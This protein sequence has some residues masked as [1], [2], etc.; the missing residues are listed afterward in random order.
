MHMRVF[1]AMAWMAG[2]AALTAT[3]GCGDDGPDRYGLSGS[4][5]Y[6]GKPIAGGWIV[7][8]PVGE[9]PGASGNIHDGRYETRK[10][11]GTVGGPHTIEVVAFDSAAAADPNTEG[12]AGTAAKPMFSC[13]IQRDIPKETTSLDIEISRADVERASR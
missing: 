1:P 3:G 13:T 10:D 2:L 6:E 11:W 8:D 5:S 12:S 9:G 7:F 4:I